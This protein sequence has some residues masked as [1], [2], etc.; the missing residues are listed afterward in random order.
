LIVAGTIGNLLDQLMLGYVRDFLK[1]RWIGTV[2]L[3]DIYATVC[4]VALVVALRRKVDSNRL[5]ARAPLR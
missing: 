4:L 5:R 3:A 1:L 2:N